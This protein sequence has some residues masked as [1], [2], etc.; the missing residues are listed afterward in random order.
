MTFDKW[1]NSDDWM[2]VGHD[3]D[4]INITHWMEIR[5]PK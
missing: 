1:W 3:C 4:V 5:L 2:E